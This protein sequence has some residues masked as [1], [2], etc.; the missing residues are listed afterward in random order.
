MAE[1]SKRELTQH[2]AAV[3]NCVTE[4]EDIVVTEQGKPRWRIVAF[5]GQNLQF[6]TPRTTG[7][8]TP[9][10]RGQYSWPRH[11]G[12]SKYTVD[13]V[14]ERL[15]EMRG[16]TDQGRRELLSSCSKADAERQ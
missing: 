4:T 2:T 15:K 16:S 9:T 6:D 12:G 3:L 1:V 7:R 13:E 11:P 8:D 10:V 14:V 5:Q